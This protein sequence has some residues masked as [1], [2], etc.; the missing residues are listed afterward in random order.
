MVYEE[1]YPEI[2]PQYPHQNNGGY[3]RL[4]HLTQGLAGEEG[5]NHNIRRDERSA[6]VHDRPVKMPQISNNS[7]DVPT[8]DNNTL[9]NEPYKATEMG[10]DKVTTGISIKIPSSLEIGDKVPTTNRMDDN[11]SDSENQ[12]NVSKGRSRSLRSISV[13][14]SLLS[15]SLTSE[16]AQT[17]QHTLYN[18]ELDMTYQVTVSVENKYGWSEL[19]D[20]FTFHTLPGECN[21]RT[22]K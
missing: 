3:P 1:T 13:A 6:N 18:L 8:I 19:S 10:N 4:Q 22:G 2:P 21:N 9:R 11:Y 17:L 16:K 14:D 20:V 15:A 7:L 5:G 12:N